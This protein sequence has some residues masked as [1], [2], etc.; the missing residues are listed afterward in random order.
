MNA[1]EELAR[2][3]EEVRQRTRLVL[4]KITSDQLDWIPAPQAL[5]IRQMA[6]HMRLSEEGSLHKSPP[7]CV[8]SVSSGRA[9]MA[10]C[11]EIPDRL[12]P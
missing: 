9:P 4:E 7:I 11:H 5:T 2:V 10:S 3:K 12:A 6:R 8:C 1:P